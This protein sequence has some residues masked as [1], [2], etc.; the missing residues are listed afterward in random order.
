MM[1]ERTSGHRANGE[2]RR[3]AVV[4][5][6]GHVAMRTLGEKESRTGLCGNEPRRRAW[7][8]QLRANPRG[9]A[10]SVLIAVGSLGSEIGVAF[11]RRQA[12]HRVGSKP[13]ER[14]TRLHRGP[15][16]FFATS[17]CVPRHFA[18][19]VGRRQMRSGGKIGQLI[20]R[21]QGIAGPHQPAD[22]SDMIADIVAGG[23]QGLGIGRTAALILG[24]MA[25]KIPARSPAA[26]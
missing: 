14:R 18:Q 23:S 15:Y 2:T 22:I 19:I 5:N 10:N 17:S 12:S 16:Q 13:P 26:G 3:L 21:R 6:R 1:I 4:A 8:R 9:S 24:H 20:D 25:L 7:Q 11:R